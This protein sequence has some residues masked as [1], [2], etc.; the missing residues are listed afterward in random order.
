MNM[1][2]F[3]LAQIAAVA[4]CI[5]L[6]LPCW[7]TF[8]KAAEKHTCGD[9]MYEVREDG[10]ARITGYTGDA[11]KVTVPEAL[12]GY[13]VTAIGYRVFSYCK[14]LTEITLPDSLT[15]IGDCAFY[16]CFNLTEIMLP[17]SLTSIG[18]W[19]FSDC[20]NL[21]EITLP[22][23]LTSIGDLAFYGCENLTEITLLD[24]LES[25][26]INPFMDSGV[27]I[28]HV[29]PD[30]PL[31]TTISGVLFS[32][33]DKRLIYYPSD[34]TD[35]AYTVPE[36]ILVIGDGAFY[37]CKNLTKITLPDNLTAIGDEAFYACRNLTEI[38][39]PDGLTAIGDRAFDGCENLTEITLPDSLTVIGE[40][41]FT[42]CRN[43]TEIT[44][45][46]GL[47]AIG[48][49]AFDGCEN[50]SSIIV[51]RNSYA[52]EYCIANDLPYS[53]ADANV[54]HWN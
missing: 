3:S 7:G 44:L 42:D 5:A 51:G 4:L 17:G 49:R 32:K 39:L 15:A 33:P 22:S 37:G 10:T 8:A 53:Y 46:D 2:K 23:S 34:R 29:S 25:I 45:P 31:L 19:A 41:A 21:T 13:A 12:D 43:L 6:L 9:F 1:K 14:N 40:A 20:E 54:W 50:L 35:S 30:H 36:D 11:S 38:T 24:S 18:P 16:C 48:D 26:G 28:I 27:Q 47:T 52:E